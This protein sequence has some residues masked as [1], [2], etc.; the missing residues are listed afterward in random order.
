MNYPVDVEM[1]LEEMTASQRAFFEECIA[2]GTAPR[3]AAMFAYRRPPGCKTDTSFLA[4]FGA[5]GSQFSDDQASGEML[6]AKARTVDP[7]FNPTGKVYISGLCRPEIGPGD[8]VAWVEGDPRG[9]IRKQCEERGLD[10]EG[11]VE[12]KSTRRDV[13]EKPYRVDDKVV[14]QHALNAV[15]ADPGLAEKKDL[16]ESVRDKITPKDL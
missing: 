8:P 5:N 1:Q 12:Y 15:A 4:K 14:I 2:L 7:N 11:A 6:T 3:A 9:Y 10:C 16:L 13:E